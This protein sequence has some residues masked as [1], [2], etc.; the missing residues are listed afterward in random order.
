MGIVKTMGGFCYI[1]CDTQNCNK[2]IE[3]NDENALKQLAKI[4]G[5]ENKGDKWACSDCVEKQ[6]PKTKKKKS[7]KSK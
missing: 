2:K 7:S 1:E 3:Q 5:W 4:C 6:A